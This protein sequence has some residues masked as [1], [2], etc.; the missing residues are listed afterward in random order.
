[1]CGAVSDTIP[2]PEREGAFCGTCGATWRHR[3]ILLAV[4]VGLGYPPEP[5]AAQESNWALRGIGISDA[6]EVASVLSAHFDYVNTW[7][8]RFPT[9]DLRQVPD[10]LRKSLD[11][12]T[13]S[14]V[15]EHVPPPV[16]PA[17][18]GLAELLQ[19]GGFAVITVPRA[20]QS[21]TIELYPGLA[22]YRVAFDRVIWV[23]SEG[24]TR[25]DPSPEFHLGQGETLAFRKWN[26]EDLVARLGLLGF[27]QPL[28]LPWSDELGLPDISDSGLMLVRKLE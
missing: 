9:V 13:C 21:T 26:F 25:I 20:S 6:T 24:L 27:S 11:F 4:L 22:E 5:L 23:D 10:E 18:R 15:L 16:D 19:P 3:A 14:E 17:L 12:V 2:Q 7:Y 28:H 8:D 1:M